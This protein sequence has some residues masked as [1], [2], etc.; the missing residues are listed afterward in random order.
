MKRET[1]RILLLWRKWWGGAAC[2]I[3]ALA[4]IWAAGRPAA[5][6]ASAKERQLPIY[7]VEKDYES[8][9]Q[10]CYELWRANSLVPV[11]QQEEI[12]D[13]SVFDTVST[14]VKLIK[15]NNI[16]WEVIAV[17]IVRSKLTGNGF[18]RCKQIRNLNIQLLSAF[19]ANEVNLLAS[20]FADGYFIASAK[21]FHVDNILKD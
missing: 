10:S 13:I 11:L 17:G 15:R 18:L 7:C 21:Q 12:A 8:P 6:G 1:V 20:S 19:I 3:A 2:L 16:L 14:H 4:M 9:S 5:V